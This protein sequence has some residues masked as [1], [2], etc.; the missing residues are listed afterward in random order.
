MIFGRFRRT[1]LSHGR[2]GGGQ[3]LRSRG[4]YHIAYGEKRKRSFVSVW[5]AYS[6]L[7]AMVTLI[8]PPL[9]LT[10]L[11]IDLVLDVI[12]WGRERVVQFGDKERQ[13]HV[14][15]VIEECCCRRAA[16]VDEQSVGPWRSLPEGEELFLVQ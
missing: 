16:R 12:S 11:L 5:R 6:S 4:T 9:L 13:H 3:Q 1:R 15:A 14:S 7:R 2:G 10:V 8:P